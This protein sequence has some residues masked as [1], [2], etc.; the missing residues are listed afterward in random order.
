M[1]AV[2]DP[3]LQKAQPKL[4]GRA[5]SVCNI[6]IQLLLDLKSEDKQRRLLAAED[7]VAYEEHL[8]ASHIEQLVPYFKDLL[9]ARL[10]DG[11]DAELCAA[12]AQFFTPLAEVRC[13]T[14]SRSKRSQIPYASFIKNSL[15]SS[16]TG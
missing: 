8:Q 3:C 16:F 5:A 11:D 1:A 15:S 9:F 2:A 14:L 10:N 4:F 7:F 6:F 12:A 13:L